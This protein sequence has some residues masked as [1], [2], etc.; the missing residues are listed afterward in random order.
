[1]VLRIS[2]CQIKNDTAPQLMLLRSGPSWRGIGGAAMRV[3][4]RPWPR[5]HRGSVEPPR[6]G[7]KSHETAPPRS[8]GGDRWWASV[9]GSKAGLD[10][11]INTGI[12]ISMEKA[13]IDLRLDPSVH[14][15]LKRLSEESGL[16]LNQ[17]LQGLAR[18]ATQTGH[19]GAPNWIDD[20]DVVQTEKEPGVVWFGRN[21]INPDGE[22]MGGG[23]V[24]LV[25]DFT[26]R[27]AVR[28]PQDY[29]GK[30]SDM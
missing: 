19:A 29:F 25:L 23:E 6:A 2:A 13:R 24:L 28:R 26:E 16:S 15:S 27:S 10:T 17:L 4:L 5:S 7:S 30:S 12:L 1:M 8:G 3:G 9:A 21:G 22:P 11:G 20:L 14:A 18:W